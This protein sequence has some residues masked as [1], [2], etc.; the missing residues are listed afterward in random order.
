MKR[1][2]THKGDQH[3]ADQPQKHKCFCANVCF[4]LFCSDASTL[5]LLHIVTSTPT[6]VC[7]DQSIWDQGSKRFSCLKLSVLQ[8][9][10]LYFSSDAPPSLPP[11]CHLP[12]SLVLLH[13]LSIPCVLW[14]PSCS[15]II[16]TL[17][18]FML[19]FLFHSLKYT[20]LFISIPMCIV[21]NI[22]KCRHHTI[23]F[24]F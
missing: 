24:F 20:H 14:Y 16:S 7:R 8:N 15:Y 6:V 10:G 22:S 1:K 18:Y 19:Y 23:L 4:F 17:S 5:K 12:S 2:V 21:K 11:D 9:K 13:H 3:L